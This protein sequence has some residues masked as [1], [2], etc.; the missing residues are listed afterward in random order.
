VAAA[1]GFVQAQAG[2]RDAALQARNRLESLAE[3]EYVSSYDLA[4]LY[5]ALGD[6]DQAVE[7]LWRAHEEYSSMLPY[8]NVDARV[9]PLRSHPRF[10]A[11]IQRMRFPPRPAGAPQSF[12]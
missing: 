8:V 7:R 4:L 2:L 11:L 9:D 5:L 1:I 6:A 3:H 10:V 12:L